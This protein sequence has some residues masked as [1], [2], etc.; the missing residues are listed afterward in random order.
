MAGSDLAH[1]ARRQHAVAVVGHAGIN[2]Y[3]D[4]VGR[5]PQLPADSTQT[6]IEKNSRILMGSSRSNRTRQL[7]PLE[8]KGSSV[9]RALAEAGATDKS[10]HDSGAGSSAAV[11]ASDVL[12]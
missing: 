3:R 11:E 10:Q 7:L 12:K 6:S 8:R 4:S 9:N 5:N 2:A 1:F